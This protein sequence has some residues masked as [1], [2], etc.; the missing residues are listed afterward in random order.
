MTLAP[1][2]FGWLWEASFFVRRPFLFPYSIVFFLFLGCRLLSGEVW[3][4]PALL[5]FSCHLF[6]SLPFLFFPA[7]PSTFYCFLPPCHLAGIFAGRARLPYLY[8]FFPPPLVRVHPIEPS[9]PP[10]R[11]RL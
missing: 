9:G 11:I 6:F 7:S 8:A 1:V 5:S 4:S 2:L 10:P 3:V